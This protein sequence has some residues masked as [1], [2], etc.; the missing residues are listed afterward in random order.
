MAKTEMIRAR[1]E[2]ELKREAEEIF[3]TL[4]LS[5]TEAITMFYRQVTFY[6]G[7]P[8]IVRIPRQETLEAIRQARSGEGLIEYADVDELM[9]EFD[10]A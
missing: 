6:Q 1:M 5:T 2:P 4:G 9:A 8:F 7:L 3:S 10:N